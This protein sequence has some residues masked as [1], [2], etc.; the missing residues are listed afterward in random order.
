MNA[1]KVAPRDPID[2]YDNFVKDLFLSKG[3]KRTLNY[4]KTQL[5]EYKNSGL[6]ESFI[7]YL[8]TMKEI[9]YKNIVKNEYKK[10]C[11]FKNESLKFDDCIFEL[12]ENY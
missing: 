8:I 6:E 2:Y 7:D 10:Y 4:H 3:H 5:A 1:C 9:T 11:I 12:I